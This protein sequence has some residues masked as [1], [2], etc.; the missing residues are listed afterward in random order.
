MVVKLHVVYSRT[1]PF[2][3]ILAAIAGASF[4]AI[5]QFVTVTTLNSRL[6]MAICFFTIALP[7]SV[8]GYVCADNFERADPKPLWAYRIFCGLV[9]GLF[10]SGMSWL[11]FSFGTVYG[12]LFTISILVAVFFVLWAYDFG[13]RF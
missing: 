10:G 9:T 1:V 7:L 12:Y 13:R 6:S 5:L 3:Q 4:I 2:R 11:M 8:A